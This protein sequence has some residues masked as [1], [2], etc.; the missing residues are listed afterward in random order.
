MIFFPVIWTCLSY[1]NWT[2]IVHTILLS[3]AKV[4]NKLLRAL[5]NFYPYTSLLNTFIFKI[6]N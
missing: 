2:A 1:D 6:C 5:F 3:F 4:I